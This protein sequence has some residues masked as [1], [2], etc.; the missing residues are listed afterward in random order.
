MH[1]VVKLDF[2]REAV[3][4]DPC[5]S[6]PEDLSQYDAAEVIIPFWDQDDSISSALLQ[7]F[8]LTEIRLDQGNNHLPF[9]G[10]RRLLPS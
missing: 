10:V 7:K 3:I 2:R 5:H 9:R 1:G 8:T 4:Q 6:L